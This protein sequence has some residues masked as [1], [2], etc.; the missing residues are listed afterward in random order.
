MAGRLGLRRRCGRGDLHPGGPLRT[1]RGSTLVEVLVA[2]A[3]FSLSV[4]TV[5]G[6]YLSAARGVAKQRE[7]LF[8]EG[9]CLDIDYYYDR[10]GASAWAEEYFGTELAGADE[11]AGEAYYDDDFAL[12]GGPAKY[13]LTYR[14]DGESGC[15]F[16]SVFN[17]DGGRYVIENL[18]YGGSKYDIARRSGAE[19]GGGGGS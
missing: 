2:L 15:L 10:F 16:V 18:N 8:F 13:T 4:V 12:C 1:R 19:S 14:Y 11:S 9:V 17:A 7:Y 5:L 6:V 3:V